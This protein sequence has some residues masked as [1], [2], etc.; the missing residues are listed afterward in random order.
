MQASCP[1]R[2]DL[3]HFLQV[4]EPE[5]LPGAQQLLLCQQLRTAGAAWQNQRHICLH[6]QV[7][8]PILLQSP[9]HPCSTSL[10]KPMV[11]V[12]APVAG[13]R[14]ETASVQCP[15]RRLRCR[16][17]RGRRQQP[18][19]HA[20]HGRRWAPELRELQQRARCPRAPATRPS[21]RAK[22]RRTRRP[23]ARAPSCPVRL[24][25]VRRPC[26]LRLTLLWSSG[27]ALCLGCMPPC[28]LQQPAC[29]GP[30]HRLWQHAC[31]HLCELR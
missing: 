6:Q 18:A 16:G 10:V 30:V 7:R 24:L 2:P 21:R 11:G 17:A 29:Q 22:R 26:V 28:S 15:V 8:R 27:A 4:R 25:S 23:A 13:S 5:L 3:W 20:R 19:P 14:R 31:L 1:C 12:A 9:A